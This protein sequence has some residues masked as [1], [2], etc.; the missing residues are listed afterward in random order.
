M[1]LRFELFTSGRRNPEIAAEFGGAPAGDARMQVAEALLAAKEHEG[2]VRLADAPEV[3][4][5]VLLSARRRP[6][7]EPAG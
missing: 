4:A 1:A 3:V 2:V 6:R 5:A 7:S